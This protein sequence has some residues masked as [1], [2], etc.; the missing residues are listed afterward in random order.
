MALM[1]KKVIGRPRQIENIEKTKFLKENGKLT[2][3]EIARVL[4]RDVKTIHR[5][6]GYGK[7]E[8]LAEG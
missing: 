1:D 6:Y 7:G 5:W 8:V 3:R 2:F 4:R